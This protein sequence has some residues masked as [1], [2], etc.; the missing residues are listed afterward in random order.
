MTL[1]IQRDSVFIDEGVHRFYLALVEAKDDKDPERYPFRTFKDVFMWAASVGY[2]RKSRKPLEK[3]RKV[4]DWGTF[5]NQVD[6]PMLKAIALGDSGDVGVLEKQEVVLSIAEEYANAGIQ[7]LYGRVAE[8][9]GRELLN[10]V[11]LVRAAET[12]GLTTA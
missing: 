8:S 9:P 6:V 7:H 3:R 2:A 5:Q 1:T 10:L 12:E 11:D 4:F